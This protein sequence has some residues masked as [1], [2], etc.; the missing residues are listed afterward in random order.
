MPTKD[1]VNYVGVLSQTAFIIAVS[2][3]YFYNNKLLDARI[4][5][6]GFVLLI[7][8]YFALM[9]PTAFRKKRGRR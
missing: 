6:L 3:A 9:I 2:W 7:F 5:S 8:S 1:W 4:L